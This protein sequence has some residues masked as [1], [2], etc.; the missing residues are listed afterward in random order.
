MTKLHLKLRSPKVIVLY[1]S[2]LSACSVSQTVTVRDAA[3]QNIAMEAP[4]APM[5]QG[6]LLKA[7]G[8]RLVGQYRY[9]A[10]TDPKKAITVGAQD[11]DGHSNV[12]HSAQLQYIR[13]LSQGERSWELGLIGAAAISM[14][15]ARVQNITTSP[16]DL[17]SASMPFLKLGLGLRGGLVKIGRFNLGLNLEGELT[18]QAYRVDIRRVKTTESTITV[19]NLF[20][21]KQEN[22]STTTST[23]SDDLLELEDHLISFTPRVGLFGDVTIIPEL[24][25][26]LGASTQLSKRYTGYAESECSYE[27]DNLSLPSFDQCDPKDTFPMGEYV[28][29]L[30]FYGGVSL[31]LELLSINVIGSRAMALSYSEHAAV[32]FQ[33]V[34]SFGLNF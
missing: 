7:E 33:L 4:G 32:P 3:Q 34:S 11:V 5:M 30:T 15:D 19:P 13:S 29:Y 31:D 10:E 8:S 9:A 17:E 26:Y 25:V 22:L 18:R 23:I 21:P 12:T 28:S 27:E 24:H 2:L 6:S 16:D 1:A 20:D 14:S